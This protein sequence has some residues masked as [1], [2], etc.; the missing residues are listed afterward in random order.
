MD[1][2]TSEPGG[3]ES[4]TQLGKEHG[5]SKVRVLGGAAAGPRVMVLTAVIAWLLVRSGQR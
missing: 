4:R 2:R 1:A 3:R 5:M